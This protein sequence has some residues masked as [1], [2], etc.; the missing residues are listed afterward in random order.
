MEFKNSFLSWLFGARSDEP[1]EIEEQLSAQSQE[2]PEAQPPDC[3]PLYSLDLAQSH[4]IFKLW[5]VYSEQTGWKPKPKLAFEGIPDLLMDDVTAKAELLRLQMVVNSTANGRFEQL[6]KVEKRG[7]EQSSLPD[8]DAQVAVFLSKDNLTAWLLAYPP[9]GDGRELDREALDRE[10]AKQQVRF[11]ID[12]ELLEA[13]PQNPERYFRLFLAAQGRAAVNGVDGRVIDLFPRTEERKLTVDENNRVDYTNLDFIHNVEKDGVICRIVPPTQ[14][15]PGRT[16]Q[17]QAVPAKA[18]K[19]AS[20]PKGRNTAVSEDG[21]SL[22]ST[23]TGHVEFSGRTF[24]VKPVLDIPGNVDFSVGNINFLG[25]VC[26]H[27]DICSGFTVRAMGNITVQGVVEACTVEAGRDL[28]VA[29]GVQGDNQAVIRAQRSVFAKYLENSCVYAKMD[30]ESECIINCDVYCGGGVTVRSGHSKIIGGKIHAAHE[31]KAGVVGSRVGNRT[32]IVLGGQPCEEFDFD[33]LTKEVQELERTL[34]RID[35]QPDSPSKI[36]RMA[37]LRMQLTLNKGKLEEIR[38][39]R[40]QRVEELQ[41]PGVRRM[42]CS[43]VFPGT[44]LTI[45]DAVHCFDDKVSPCSAT[46]AD[47]GIHL[48]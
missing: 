6:R 16:V 34:E 27:G 31:V 32:D 4:A 17:D 8:L 24:Q 13:L 11:G 9:V 12:E 41:D 18:G 5:T 19:P 21:Q 42:E 36:S 46:L 22:V 44:V 14:G 43:T 38:K 25:D 7:E 48:I 40:E 35:R 26:I 47:D 45:G 10:L 1:E 37:K 30:L 28:V 2:R 23:I 20:V 3:P 15:E 29:R 33:L 39:D